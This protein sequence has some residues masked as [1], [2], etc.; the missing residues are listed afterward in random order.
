MIVVRNNR[1]LAFRNLAKMYLETKYTE[2]SET[3][4]QADS[5]GEENWRKTLTACDGIECLTAICW[6]F[7]FS[8]K[9]SIEESWS[10]WR[11]GICG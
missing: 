11:C 2:T 1:F 7:K 10:L 4:S 3:C 6:H 8:S 5:G 9:S